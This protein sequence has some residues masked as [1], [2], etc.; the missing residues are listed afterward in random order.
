MKARIS[1]VHLLGSVVFVLSFVFL[2]TTASAQNLVEIYRK[3]VAN[4]P[5][6]RAS[7]FDHEASKE[8]VDQA[9][10]E[11]LPRI[12][13]DYD[14]IETTQDV[15]SSDNAVF[16]VGSTDFP[17]TNWSLTL[18]QPIFR[19][20]N[21]LRIK[22]AKTELRQ[23]DVEKIQAHQDL[24]LRT[25]EAYLE[26]LAAEDSLSFNVAEQVAVRQQLELAKGREEAEIGRRVDRLD[27]EARLA[28]VDADLAEAEVATLDAHEAIYE[29]IGETPK[30]LDRLG[31]QMTLV[32]PDPVD[33][34]HWIDAALDNNLN[35]RVQREAVAVAKREISRQK[36]GHYP[37]LDL[38]YRNSNRETEGTLFGGGS[39]VETQELM[40]R[41][42][43][44]IYL[45]GSVNS[46]T[47]EASANYYSEQEELVRLSREARREAQDAY[48]GVLNAIKRVESLKKA[49]AS[50]QETLKLKRT[51]Y[52]NGLETALSVLD[53]ER[54]LYSAQ[55]DYSRA[56]YDYLLNSLRLKAMVGTLTENDLLSVNRWLISGS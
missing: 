22:Q 28:T 51:S 33:L 34:Q 53:S 29:I 21:Y 42:N 23:A 40:L 19:Y 39:E 31:D 15:V 35:V 49:V 25:A 17:T 24:I 14:E 54:D 52:D 5:A 50:Q 43:L 3:A 45:G 27:A 10:A 37:T 13:F 46:R 7:E 56:R 18:T 55:R 8:V 11:Y 16:A 44:P 6:F 20:A 1:C 47:R 36:A 12:E 32:S 9:W 30:K 41:F 48:W 4:D 38:V 2:P 26:A